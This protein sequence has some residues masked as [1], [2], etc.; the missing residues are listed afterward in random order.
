MGP[1]PT[2]SPIGA[3]TS[4]LAFG[5][6]F[7]SCWASRPTLSTALPPEPTAKPNGSTRSWSNIFRCTSTTN[8]TIGQP[9]TLGPSLRTTT[10]HT[11]QPWLPLSSLTRA[12]NPKLE[13]SLNLWC[14]ITAHQVRQPSRS[15]IGI[16][17]TRYLMPLNSTSPLRVVTRPNPP[18]KVGDTVWLDAWNIRTTRPLRSLTITSWDPFRSWRKYHHTHSDLVCP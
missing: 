7:A 17:A 10:R 1:R 16:F 3:S 4:S 2:S 6:H 11:L 9:P 8:K 15:S 18:F 5:G 13:V 12:F 14:R